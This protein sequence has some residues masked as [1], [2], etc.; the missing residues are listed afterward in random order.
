MK[1]IVCLAS[2]PSVTRGDVEQCRS[3]PIIAINNSIDLAPWATVLLGGDLKWWRW[4]SGM[5]SFAG[6]KVT[7]HRAAADAYPDVR[8]LQPTGIRGFESEPGKVR[9][10]R[11]SG[12]VAIQLAAQMGAMRIVLL[13]YDMRASDT[14]EHHWHAPHPDGS[15]PG[16]DRCLPLFDDLVEPLRSRGIAIVNCSPTTAL[17]AFPCRPL[18]E[19]LGLSRSSTRPA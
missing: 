8:W 4:R 14:G 11:N 3:L 16:F 7:C 18:S 13:G 17:R 1:T 12:Y 5:P 2:G 15:H 6:D 10:G 19:V 9:T